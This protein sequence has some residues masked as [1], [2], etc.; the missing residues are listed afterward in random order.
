MVFY[1]FYIL[2]HYST[3]V[4]G[5]LAAMTNVVSVVFCMSHAFYFFISLAAY[6]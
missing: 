5:R 6:T 4:T 1:T 3:G 2:V